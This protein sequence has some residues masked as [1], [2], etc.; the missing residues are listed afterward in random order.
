[1]ERDYAVL[2]PSHPYECGVKVVVT[3]PNGDKVSNQIWG[4][5]KTEAEQ[6][7]NQ[8]N[9]DAI[10]GNPRKAYVLYGY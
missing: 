9:G 7:A 6:I 10:E 3:L 4:L 8:L 2:E 5:T 1:M